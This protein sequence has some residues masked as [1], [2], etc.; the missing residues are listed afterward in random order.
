MKHS[1][2][3]KPLILFVVILTV[4]SASFLLAVQLHEDDSSRVA[5]SLINQR[6]ETVDQSDLAG[7]YQL[8]IFGFTSC[9][10]ICPTQMSKLTRAMG[11][12]D[13]TGHGQRVTPI[14]ISIDPERDTPDKIAS[15]LEYFDD[16]FIGLTGSRAALAS[17]TDAFKTFLQAAPIGEQSEGYQLTHSSIVYV[18]DPYNRIVDYVP[19]EE[20]YQAIAERIRDII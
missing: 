17:A 15:Y 10:N 14:F 11:E 4:I 3:G 12:L 20:G 19:F 5:Y 2:W 13:L 6:H 9:A 7:K 16:R 8:V 18:V 1:N